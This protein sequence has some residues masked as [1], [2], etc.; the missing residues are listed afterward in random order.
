MADTNIAQDKTDKQLDR[1]R[2]E[3]LTR[4]Y[5]SL[6][7]KTVKSIRPMTRSECDD[8]AWEYGY[9]R[10]ACVIVFTDGTAVVPMA[11][12]EGNGAGFLAVGELS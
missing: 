1:E 12:P 4:E 7:G 11:D 5:G 2:Q 8:L 10:D 6:V 3:Y 9:E